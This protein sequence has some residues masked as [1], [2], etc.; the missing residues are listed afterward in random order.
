MHKC[1]REGTRQASP[2]DT[3]FFLKDFIYL[4]LRDPERGR[5]RRRRGRP[6]GE[7]D[8]GLEPGP[9]SPWAE[10]AAPPPSPGPGPQRAAQPPRAPPPRLARAGRYLAPEAPQHRPRAGATL[11]LPVSLSYAAFPFEEQ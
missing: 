3:N 4:F 10:A 9:G 7:P 2:Q 1:T 8:A 6:C 11:R 5:P